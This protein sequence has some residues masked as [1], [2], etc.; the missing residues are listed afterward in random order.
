MQTFRPARQGR[1]LKTRQVR[2]VVTAQRGGTCLTGFERVEKSFHVRQPPAT[3][4]TK[5][6][7]TTNRFALAPG[8]NFLDDVDGARRS[9]NQATL[10]TG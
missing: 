4:Q 5:P 10:V 1:A 6:E 9:V 8:A 2:T 7:D 3:N